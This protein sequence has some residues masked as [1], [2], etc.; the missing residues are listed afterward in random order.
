MA[1]REATGGAD[2]AFREDVLKGLGAREKWLSPRWL[3]DQRGSELFEQI[4][5]LPEYYPTRT[6]RGILASHAGDMAEAI[7][8]GAVLVEYGA[9][10]ATKTR[11]LLGAMDD[12]AAYVPVDISMD[13]LMDT[14]DALRAEYPHLTV[15]PV[16]G[17]FL[18]ALDLSG[19]PKARRTGFFPGSTVGNMTDPQIVDFFRA[20]RRNLGEDAQFLLGFDLKKDPAVLVP[21]YNDTAGITEAFILNTL[22]RINLELDGDFDLDA[23]RLLTEWDEALG[24]ITMWIVS[25]RDQ[26]V[27]VA[28]QRFEFTAGER[29][30]TSYSRKFTPD[31]LFAIV[32]EAGW[33]PVTTWTD[34]K[35]YFAMALLA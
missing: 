33:S 5:E 31:G 29:I 16:A 12:L 2:P 14:A 4:T 20:A 8:P 21:A 3:Y 22:N 24:Q 19:V 11:I 34:P 13:F 25:D 35:G 18:G 26:T 15:V 6:E 27:T 17:D 28:G 23:F 10:A 32:R 7:G 9:G 1:D 30:Y